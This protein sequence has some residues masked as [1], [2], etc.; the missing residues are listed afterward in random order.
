MSQFTI[1]DLREFEEDFNNNLNKDSQIFDNLMNK[2]DSFDFEL[3]EAEGYWS[4]TGYYG[5]LEEVIFP[6][7]KYDT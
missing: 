4:V 7:K 2:E 5:K 6:N 3:N 1:D